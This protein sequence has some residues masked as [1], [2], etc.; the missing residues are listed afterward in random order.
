MILPDPNVDCIDVF[1][2]VTLA[3]VVK[4]SFV[5]AFPW[6]IYIESIVPSS[7]TPEPTTFPASSYTN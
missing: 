3:C 5:V 6:G 1:T 2:P 4:F 7:F